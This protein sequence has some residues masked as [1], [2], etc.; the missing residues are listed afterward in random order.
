VPSIAKREK[1]S[2][3]TTTRDESSPEGAE[4]VL[5][6]AVVHADDG[7]RFMTVAESRRDLVHRVAEYVREWGGY[8]LRPDHARHLRSL[9]ARGES[10]AAVELYFGLVGKRWDKEWLVT[11]VVSADRRDVAAVLGE[12]ALPDALADRESRG[13]SGRNGASGSGRAVNKAFGLYLDRRQP[14][15]G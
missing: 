15:L 8:L 13:E 10:E 14:A 2:T 1:S 3:V 6:V 4:H 9:L 12:V 11:A 7:V 5:F